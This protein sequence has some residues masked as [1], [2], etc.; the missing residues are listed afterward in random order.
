[1]WIP[2]KEGAKPDLIATTG[3][4]L[5][6][7]EVNANNEIKSKCLLNNVKKKKKKSKQR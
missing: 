6:L 1:M 7:W 4:Y 5:R 3:D 2:D